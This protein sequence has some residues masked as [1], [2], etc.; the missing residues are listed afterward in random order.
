MVNKETIREVEE[1]TKR[2]IKKLEK[3]K[4]AVENKLEWKQ[5]GTPPWPF[6]ESAELKRA[7]L[8]LSKALSRMRKPHVWNEDKQ[9]WE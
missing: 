8:D 2:F 7:S 3:F 5:Y 4:T 9:R 6:T 1:E